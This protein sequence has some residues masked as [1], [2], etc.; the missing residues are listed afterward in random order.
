MGHAAAEAAI[1]LMESRRRI[2][3][4]KAFGITLNVAYAR[5]DYSREMGPVK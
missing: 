2:A 4:P 5:A 1:T 3:F